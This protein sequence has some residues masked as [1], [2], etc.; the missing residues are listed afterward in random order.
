MVHKIG[1]IPADNLQQVPFAYKM[2][3]KTDSTGWDQS[4][5][6]K[7]AFSVDV[8]IHFVGVWYVHNLLYSQTF[9]PLLGILLILLESFPNVS[10]SPPQ[11]RL[12]VPS[13]MLYPSTSDVSSSKRTSGTGQ[14][15]KRKSLGW[16][17]LRPIMM[18]GDSHLRHFKDRRRKTMAN[19]LI[20]KTAG[21]NSSHWFRMPMGNWTALNQ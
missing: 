1:L 20:L 5:G 3:T 7:K 9:S 18:V 16:T 4:N 8:P 10:L 19:S 14:Q 13:D 21:Q 12:S 11:I 2:Y 17:L 6:F 15:T